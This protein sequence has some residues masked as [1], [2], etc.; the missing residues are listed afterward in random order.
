MP[1]QRGRF[2]GRGEGGSDVARVLIVMDLTAARVHLRDPEDF[3]RFSVVVDG[4]GDLEAL[5][6]RSGIG[7]L[8]PAGA[9]VVVDPVALRALAGPAATA[10]WD[11]GLA[12]MVAYA[13]GRGWVEND[14]GVVAHVEGRDETG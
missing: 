6:D 8:R 9:H 1:E 7:R 3:T 13:A 2:G 11:E 4:V 5:V 14:G 12:G 10:E